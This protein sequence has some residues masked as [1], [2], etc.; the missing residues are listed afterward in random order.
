MMLQSVSALCALFMKTQQKGQRRQ[1]I[2]HVGPSG[3]KQGGEET[4][5]E[6]SS[7]AQHLPLRMNREW[8]ALNAASVPV[9]GLW[10]V[11]WLWA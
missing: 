4:R 10:E 2:F 6:T 3:M 11:I 9:G 8:K 5:A 1:L 7:D